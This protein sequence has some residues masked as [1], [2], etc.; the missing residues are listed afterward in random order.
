MQNR[1]VDVTYLDA[2][3]CV[4]EASCTVSFPVLLSFGES[5]DSLVNEQQ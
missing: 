1:P 3:N 5:E 4:L 2:D